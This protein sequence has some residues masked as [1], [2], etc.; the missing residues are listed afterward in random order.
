MG[1]NEKSKILFFF[2]FSIS[3]DHTNIIPKRTLLTSKI[4]GLDFYLYHYNYNLY[5]TI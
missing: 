5:N 2:V 3:K 4:I 1:G